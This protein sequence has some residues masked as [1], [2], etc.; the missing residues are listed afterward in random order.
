MRRFPVLVLALVAALAA[1]A[2]TPAAAT[3][4]KPKAAKKKPT[5]TRVTPMRLG[6][7]QVMTIR[8][9]NFKA[10]AR[11]NTVVFQSG[12]GRTAFAKP[13]RA[14][15]RKL[16]VKLPAAVARLLTVKDSA[17][18]PTRL[19]L[20]VLSGRTFGKFTS[21]RLSPIVVALGEG[22]GAG[23]P[24]ICKD[25]A[26]HDNDLLPNTL[27]AANGMDPCLADTDDDG[28]TDG[29]EYYAALDL[30]IKAV[31]YPGKRPYPN[32]L[33]PSDATVDFDGDSLTGKVEF[34]LW[35]YAGSEFDAGRIGNHTAGSPLGYSDGTQRSRPEQVPAV[36]AFRS[37]S[38]GIAITPPA[39][40]ARLDMNGDTSNWRDDERDADRDG[41]NNFVE[42]VGPG[43][44]EWWPAWLAEQSIEPWPEVYFGAFTLR[45]FADADPADP[46]VDGDTL[47]DGEDDQDNDD[48]LN[49]DEM[50]DP[51]QVYVPTGLRKNAFNPCAPDGESRTCPPYA[52][53]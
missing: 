44:V 45:P 33:D 42:S 36:P 32:P 9:K 50:Y 34:K 28:A 16:V 10:R 13:A 39:Y 49:Y 46:D 20:R 51:D 6:V 14:S 19:K 23:A 38:Y 4:A 17:Q 47:L 8:G 21:R 53:L 52:P 18:Q 11:R 26:D 7:G 15:R 43:I 24:A 25:D 2:A 30:N 35:R 12:N 48:I 40:P 22:P 29:W 5:I 3:A 1:V 37:P 41:L 31:P 27:E